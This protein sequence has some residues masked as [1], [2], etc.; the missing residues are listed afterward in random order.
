[1]V[2]D[3]TALGNI[4]PAYDVVFPDTQ[5][6]EFASTVAINSFANFILRGVARNGDNKGGVLGLRSA[7]IVT[8]RK[9]LGTRWQSDDI[10]DILEKDKDNAIMT[11]LDKMHQIKNFLSTLHSN[12]TEM[13]SNEKLPL[14][15]NS[16]KDSAS[17]EVVKD[18][19]LLNNNT[20][21]MIVLALPAM[22][23]GNLSFDSIKSKFLEIQAMDSA[24]KEQHDKIGS[25]SKKTIIAWIKNHIPFADK[26]FS[27][28]T[29][30][31]ESK[32]DA[33]QKNEGTKSESWI[34]SVF[35]S[36]L[37]GSSAGSQPEANSDTSGTKEG[38]STTTSISTTLRP[39]TEK[40]FEKFVDEK[41]QT[42]AEAIVTSAKANCFAAALKPTGEYST[43]LVSTQNPEKCVSFKSEG[44]FLQNLCVKLFP[45]TKI[46]DYILF[47]LEIAATVNFDPTTGTLI[48]GTA[49]SAALPISKAIAD[50]EGLA[51]PVRL[52]EI[53]IEDATNQ[54]SAEG[55][56][57]SGLTDKSQQLSGD[58]EHGD[59]L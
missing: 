41:A 21:A 59:D 30:K 38:A 49:S 48:F 35:K 44:E 47:H 19:I 53:A 32:K 45:E 9:A 29:E 1:M 24:A 40:L 51:D 8:I 26:W 18:L 4:A 46:D 52:L 28:P 20:Q 10:L 54:K 3:S 22:F 27:E 14:S 11:Y 13:V 15:L 55:S 12:V 23:S 5:Y 37:S 6:S 58:V 56:L 34:G 31:S 16:L 39:V 42:I 2:K 25:E 43:C 7:G 50:L 17:L 36:F 57:P 33:Q